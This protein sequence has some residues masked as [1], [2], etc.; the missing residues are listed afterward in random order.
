MNRERGS[1]CTKSL[2]KKTLETGE[3]TESHSHENKELSRFA[4]QTQS[5]KAK[6]SKEL[7][8]KLESQMEKVS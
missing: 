7:N 4:S 3:P 6:A 8:V 1:K 2:Y 5:L